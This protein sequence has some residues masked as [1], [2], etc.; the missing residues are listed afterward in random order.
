MWSGRKAITLPY[1]CEQMFQYTSFQYTVENKDEN[2][3]KM[4]SYKQ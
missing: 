4:L 1:L 2:K 3:H